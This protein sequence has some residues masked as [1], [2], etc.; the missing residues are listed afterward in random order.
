MVFRINIPIVGIHNDDRYWESPDEFRPERF[1]KENKHK[2]IHGTYL[3][4]GLGPR[5]CIG[6]QNRI[7][8]N[9]QWKISNNQLY[10]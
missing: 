9:L 4:F 3:P 2:I 8:F 5:N 7:Q 6:V 1:S 10:F